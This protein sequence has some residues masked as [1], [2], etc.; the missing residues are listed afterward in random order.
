MAWWLVHDILNGTFEDEYQFKKS[1]GRE[2][3]LSTQRHEDD[4]NNQQ[5]QDCIQPLHEQERCRDETEKRT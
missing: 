1:T 5:R 3:C 4:C 2:S